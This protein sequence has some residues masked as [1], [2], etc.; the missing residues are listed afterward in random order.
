MRVQEVM[1]HDPICCTQN[2]DIASAAAV[3]TD[4]NTSMVPITE[5]HYHPSRFLGVI[6]QRDLCGAVAQGKD[7]LVTRIE[8]CMSA[9]S[10]S[11]LPTD[12]VAHALCAMRASGLLR[13]PV[14]SHKK[15]LLGTISMGD[16]IRHHAAE[17]AELF[18]TLSVIAI[19]NA[20]AK[21]P[22]A[23]FRIYTRDKG[24]SAAS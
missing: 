24:F 11:C 5:Y 10:P 18:R 9:N 23:K 19:A 14:L 12:D 1:T 2:D 21:V 16:I 22:V 20:P 8:E 4:G 17:S 7:P 13:I 6:T 15:E 3:M